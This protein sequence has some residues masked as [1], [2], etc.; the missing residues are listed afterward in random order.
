MKISIQALC[1]TILVLALASC[2]WNKATNYETVDGAAEHFKGK[3]A[4]EDYISYSACLVEKSP[5]EQKNSAQK[6]HTSKVQELMM[7][8]DSEQLCTSYL[9]TLRDNREQAEASGCK[10]PWK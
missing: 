2:G 4:C 8:P 7:T 3:T 1:A 10:V 9:L 5:E 6:A